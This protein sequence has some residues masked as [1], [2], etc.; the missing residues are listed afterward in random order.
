MSKVDPGQDR[1]TRIKKKNRKTATPFV[2]AQDR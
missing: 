2:V 1:K